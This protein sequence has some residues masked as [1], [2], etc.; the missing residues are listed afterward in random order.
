[1]GNNSCDNCKEKTVGETRSG[2]AW[3]GAHYVLWPLIFALVVINQ[4]IHQLFR[5]DKEKGRL[6]M[7]SVTGG[8]TAAGATLAC[9]QMKVYGD[10]EVLA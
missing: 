6:K 10:K 9:A 8:D 5:K 7:L 3:G 4:F 1:M 2:Y